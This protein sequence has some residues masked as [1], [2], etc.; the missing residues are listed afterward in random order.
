MARP[1][2]KFKIKE[3]PEGSVRIYSDEEIAE[4]LEEDKVPPELAEWAAQLHKDLD[5]R[6]QC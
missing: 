5:D 2:F 4:F 3:P 1:S 6:L